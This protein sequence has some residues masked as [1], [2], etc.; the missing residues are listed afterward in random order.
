MT[1]TQVATHQA[2]TRTQAPVAPRR[3][4]T[5]RASWAAGALIVLLAAVIRLWG[6]PG[7]PVL[8]FDSGVYLGEGAFLASA[9]QRAAT[10]LAT[11]GSAGPLQRVAEATAQGT[12]AHP[13]DIAKPGHALL[14]AAS[15]LLLGKTAFAGTIVSALSGIGTVAATYALGM[16]G[17][18]P[19][20]AIP[21]ALFLAVSGQ[22]LVYSREPLVEADGL[23]FATLGSLLYVRARRTRGLLLAGVVF[24]LAFT[25]NNR[26]GYL[27]VVLFIAELAHWAGW[28]HLVKRGVLIGLGFAAPLAV[29]EAAYLVARGVGRA[30]GVPTEFLDYGQQL[31]AFARMN[32]PDRWRPDEWPTYFVDLGLMDG[33]VVLGL[34]VIGIV[35]VVVQLRHLER[36]RRID[37]LLAGSLLVPLAL[38]SVYST[39]EVRMRHFSLAI[40]WV[41]LAAALALA[42]LARLAGRR[43]DLVLGAATAIICALALPRVVALDSAPNGMPAV[44]AAV[45]SG[46]VAGTNGPV[47]AFYVGE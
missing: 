44:V 1:S 9:A 11:S 6:L 36:L 41:M 2:I 19:R 4:H 27:P 15:M 21:A 20:V 33:L 18:G 10:A 30:A 7:Q 38:Y 5:P 26:I 12:D 34:F 14:V 16:H 46:P 23:F 45:G 35:Q 24:G 43:R 17:W 22:H 13:P 40:P 37:M 29:I 28:R 32:A 42:A 39:G 31:A 8:Y 3:A 47:L 25:C